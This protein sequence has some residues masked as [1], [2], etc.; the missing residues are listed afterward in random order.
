MK[1]TDIKIPE[2]VKGY[3]YGE[4]GSGKTRT[5]STA[6]KPMYMFDC[7]KGVQ[8]IAG[9]PG[10]EYD[11]YRPESRK[12]TLPVLNAVK[13]KIAELQ[14]DCPFATVAL[15]S[16]TFYGNWILD[17]L[18]T[19]NNRWGQTP[20]LRKQD[21][22]TLADELAELFLDL[23]NIDANV[24]ITGHGRVLV[25]DED[26]KNT[27][28]LYLPLMHGQKFPQQLPM[29]FDELYRTVIKI[30][31]GTSDNQY[32]LQTQSDTRWSAKTRLTR[33]DKKKGEIVNV[34]DKYEESNLTMLIE[35]VAK[36]RG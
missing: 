3:I 17:K 5:L 2:N 29:Y 14:R 32:V 11:L 13:T 8:T 19:I 16:S 4:S 10:I 33:Y 26:S 36:A 18:I 21:Y 24:F 6:P 27:S 9:V 28:T 31:P 20:Q 23:L 7:D 15:D 12:K 22:G 25:P 34:L 30:K 35:K 1:T